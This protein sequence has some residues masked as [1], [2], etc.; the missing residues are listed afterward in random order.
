MPSRNSCRNPRSSYCLGRSTHLYVSNHMASW[1]G[2]SRK[3][4][5]Q[6]NNRSNH[7]RQR[8]SFFFFWTAI[9]CNSIQNFIATLS[10]RLTLSIPATRLYIEQAV[11]WDPLIF[12]LSLSDQAKALI[13]SPLLSVV[14]N[15][16][17]DASQCPWIAIIDSLDEYH[18]RQKQC[19]VLDVLSR[20]LQNL[21]IS[22]AVVI[23]S[24]PEHHIRS[25]FDLGDLNKHSSQL[26]LDDSYNPDADIKKYLVDRFSRIQEQHP[27]Q[28]Y[29]PTPW[30]M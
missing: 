18:D 7:L 12:S 14:D 4:C 8:P 20:I 1:A 30:P 9:G 19:E 10:Y 3:I 6:T 11:E 21:S 29:L 2:R 17:F 16:F 26:S 22:F 28:A 27:L 5:D 15:P 24:R 25:A 13:I 23:A